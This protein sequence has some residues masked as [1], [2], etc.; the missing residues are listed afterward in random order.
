MG[1]TRH[2]L[3]QHLDDA[4]HMALFYVWLRH[5]GGR[6]MPAENDID[7][8]D[9]APILAH[10]GLVD[11]L[12]GGQRFRCRPIGP[13][14]ASAPGREA[15]EDDIDVGADAPHLAWLRDLY[16]EVMRRRTPIYAEC[17]YKAENARRI[18]TMRL[19]LPLAGHRD[20]VDSLVYS[21]NFAPGLARS[22]RIGRIVDIFEA[23]R[24]IFQQQPGRYALPELAFEALE[25]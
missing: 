13:G 17:I 15:G 11:A 4:V 5:A 16:A 8:E 6:S 22:A 21:V 25:L 2:P 10:I 20:R 12:G 14:S 3:F 9:L 23:K 1:S 7:V 18:W 19:V 24:V